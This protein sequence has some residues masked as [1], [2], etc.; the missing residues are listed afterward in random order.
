MIQLFII[1]SL[2]PALPIP[3]SNIDRDRHA[4]LVPRNLSLWQITWYF[5]SHILF[6]FPIYLFSVSVK[7]SSYSCNLSTYFVVCPIW[8]SSLVI[9]YF[10]FSYISDLAPRAT[11]KIGYLFCA[12]RLFIPLRL[13]IYQAQFLPKLE[14]CIRV[15]DGA[16][17]SL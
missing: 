12:K 7:R 2:N 10:W 4:F 5:T 16:S 15:S 9:G 17:L 14:Y 3:Q 11:C 6:T 8:K 1:S 13:F